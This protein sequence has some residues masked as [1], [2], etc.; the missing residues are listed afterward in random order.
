MNMQSLT[1]GLSAQKAMLIYLFSLVVNSFFTGTGA[2]ALTISYLKQSFLR[3]IFSIC[4]L[5][6]F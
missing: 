1:K 2:F 6:T 4:N 3:S 5:I